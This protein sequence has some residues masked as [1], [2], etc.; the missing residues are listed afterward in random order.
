MLHV[1]SL[2]PRKGLDVLLAA[3]QG[4]GWTLVLAGSTSYKGEGLRAA[5][6]H[7]GAVVIGGASDD[8][9]VGLYRAA[10][11]VAA[12]AIYEGFGIVPLE[13]MACGTPAVVAANAG[14]LEEVSGAAAVVVGERTPEA[15]GRGSRRRGGG[16]RSSRPPGSPTPRATAGPTWRRRRASSSRRR[17]LAAALVSAPRVTMVEFG[18]RGG[19][20]DYT[21]ELVA[22]LAGAGWPVELVTARDHRFRPAPGVT[23]LPVIPWIRGRA[24]PRGWPAGCGSGPPSTRCASS[25]PSRASSPP[26]GAPA[27]RTCRASTSPR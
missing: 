20:T 26:G 21:Q 8:E 18:G 19:V 23:V 9:L 17:R 5:A 13:A 6:E 10:E 16:G 1:G 14:A 7:A 4:A 24:R 11:A 27:S 15:G 22:A 2:E 25:R 3:A 12:P